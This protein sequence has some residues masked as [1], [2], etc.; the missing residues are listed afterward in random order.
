[1]I[2]VIKALDKDN[3]IFKNLPD[4]EVRDFPKEFFKIS[5]FSFYYFKDSLKLQTYQ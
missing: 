1:M 5:E 3:N 2:N 4:E